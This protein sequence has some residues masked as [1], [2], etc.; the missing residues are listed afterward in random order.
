MS[1]TIASPRLLKS[2]SERDTD[3]GPITGP[4][5]L[6]CG[7]ALFVAV[8]FVLHHKGFS[9][10][11][12]YDS[13]FLSDN[14]RSFARHDLSEVVRIEPERSFTLLTF[15]VN[16]LITGMNPYYFRLVNAVI[17]AATGLVLALMFQMIF[18]I[19]GLPVPGSQREKT[20]VGWFLGLLFVV[21]PV[22]NLVVLYVWQRTAIMACFF[23]FSAVTVYVGARSGRFTK[24]GL[25]YALVSVLVTA[26]TL[27]KENVLT[28]PA[29]LLLAEAT[30]FRQSFINL[31]K[32][33]AVLALLTLPALLVYILVAH[34]LHEPTSLEPQGVMKRLHQHYLLS[35]LTPV[36]VLM[37]ESRVFFSYMLM[38][39]APFADNVQLIKAETIS[40]TLWAPPSTIFACLGLIGLL[41][42]GIT[43]LRTARLIAFGILFTPIVLAPELILSPQYLFF[44]HRAVLPMAGVLLLLGQAI[45]TVISK[46]RA[47][48]PHRALLPASALAGLLLVVSLGFVT[49]SSA[50]RWN[51][52]NFWQH[53]YLKLPPLS[54][55][56]QKRPYL[57]ILSN[58]G[59]ELMKARRYPEAIDMFEK[60]LAIEPESHE[61]Y[62]NLGNALLGQG[63]AGQ[64]VTYYQRAIELKPDSAQARMALGNALLELGKTSE[65]IKQY[66]RARELI[67]GSAAPHIRLAN[68]LHL[69]GELSEAMTAYRKAIELNPASVEAHTRLGNILLGQG[70]VQE[71][72]AH[73]RKAVDAGPD[74][75][76]SYNNVG[77]AL[78]RLNRIPEARKSFEKAVAL[79]P[80]LA[81]AYANLGIASLAL[82]EPDKAMDYLKKSLERDD[83]LALAHV[84]LGHAYVA[85]GETRQAARQYAKALEI[86]PN[87]LD[88]HYSLANAMAALGEVDPAKEHYHKVLQMDPRH[89]KAH[90]ALGVA[91][92]STGKLPEAVHHF[93]KALDLEPGFVDARKNL[94]KAL[95]QQGNGQGDR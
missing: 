40:R 66:N 23:Y 68:V 54:G 87:Q 2:V 7:F 42:L 24:R 59:G 11:F 90:N 58:Y 84:Y 36:Q 18:L 85:T 55:D 37:T 81:Q 53:S 39:L 63:R 43:T 75:A 56:I 14:V 67:P 30:L 27:C 48:V 95:R 71:A 64:A 15:Y 9:S 65:A 41:V 21:H 22:Q 46:S 19:P 80:G 70:K 57:H 45:L 50:A 28:V 17:M 32:K 49:W 25:S 47:R 88:A 82:G 12:I 13:T 5:E 29:V 26:G 79:Q 72:L 61:I 6:A 60:A 74:S 4:V 78:L 76:I 62:G 20:S 93:R 44:G 92:A 51:P 86:A 38:I 35:G 8:A 16:Y 31:G 10:P 69:S 34:A 94:E 83:R 73:Y 33:A 77:A 91:L 89:Y 3:A 52:F 1:E